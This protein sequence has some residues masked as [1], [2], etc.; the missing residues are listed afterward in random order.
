MENILLDEK[1]KKIKLIGEWRHAVEESPRN[2]P[3]LYSSIVLHEAGA[4]PFEI[5]M[6]INGVTVRVLLD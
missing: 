3:S 2:S 4:A 5:L 1:K 6:H